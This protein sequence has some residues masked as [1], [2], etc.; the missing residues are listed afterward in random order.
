MTRHRLRDSNGAEIIVHT[1][2]PP[3]VANNA[4]VEGVQTGI[5]ALSEVDRAKFIDKT[6]G[7]EMEQNG[8]P[9]NLLEW[10][11][12]HYK[13][14]SLLFLF[15]FLSLGPGVGCRLTLSP[16]IKFGCEF[17]L[18]RL[19][20]RFFGGGR[21]DIEF[22]P[23]HQPE[24]GRLAVRTRIRWHRWSVSPLSSSLFVEL[25]ANYTIFPASGTRSTLLRSPTRSTM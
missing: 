12:E 16:P 8:D 14:V 17:E 5:N 24:S 1:H 11:S 4:K 13:E 21:A 7:L 10:F 23:G 6:T 15:L 25:L 22:D 2:A 19:Y 9:I 3:P 18:V 20:S